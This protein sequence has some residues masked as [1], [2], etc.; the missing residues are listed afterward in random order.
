MGAFFGAIDPMYAIDYS[1]LINTQGSS[2]SI[3]GFTTVIKSMTDS[4]I[5]PM[6]DE[7]DVMGAMNIN[8]SI[9]KALYNGN[10]SFSGLNRLGS[11]NNLSLNNYALD[12]KNLDQNIYKEALSTSLLDLYN[13]ANNVSVNDINF[14]NIVNE[15][16]FSKEIR[17]DNL[18]I[19]MS[20][21]YDNENPSLIYEDLINDT[22]EEIFIND[23]NLDK[24]N[25]KEL[26]VYI[27]YV[28]MQDNKFS[29]SLS[30][31]LDI[32]DEF[33]ESD[34]KVLTS[35][36]K[37]MKRYNDTKISYNEMQKEIDKRNEE[38]EK[39]DALFDLIDAIN[40][41]YSKYNKSQR[42]NN[43]SRKNR[44]AY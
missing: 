23:I 37:N 17:N 22:K 10:N 44:Y 34:M 11:L 20:E 15:K 36:A 2:S 39:I 32:D 1:T 7:D 5:S 19:Y 43:R 26:S 33:S 27:S 6:Y 3:K 12:L 42:E 4:G 18:K 16:Y 38:N 8:P 35:F 28:T 40:E 31:L 21:N 29:N 9:Y 13:S 14:M 41:M 25:K 24:A 30:N